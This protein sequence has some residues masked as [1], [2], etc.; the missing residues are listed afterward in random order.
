MT[1]ADNIQPPAP[2]DGFDSSYASTLN[3]LSGNSS[4]MG[5]GDMDKISKVPEQE[6]DRRTSNTHPASNAC[7]E[8]DFNVNTE[9]TYPSTYS[10]IQLPIRRKIRPLFTK[11]GKLRP[12][13]LLKEDVRN[14]RKRY[15]SDWTTFNQLVFASAVY[16]FFTNLLPG[17]TFASDLYVRTGKSWGTIEIVFSTGLCGIIFSMWASTPFLAATREMLTTTAFLSNLWI[18]WELQA[19]S[20]CWLR[21]SMNY[22]FILFMWVFLLQLP[23][24]GNEY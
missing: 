10:N 15:L 24:R 5:L 21:T 11:K 17:I 23:K 4:N 1:R 7:N 6:E 20:Q 13:R 18:S 16:V 3:A 2:E 12:F 8:K 19:R 22:A 14:I 9:T